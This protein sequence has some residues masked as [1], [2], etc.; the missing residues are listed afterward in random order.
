M[1]A[2]LHRVRPE[3]MLI[4]VGDH[5]L[6]VE[7]PEKVLFEADGITKSDLVAYY[8]AVSERF[9]SYARDHPMVLRRFPD[10]ISEPG[11][12][13]KQVPEWYPSWIR[14]VSVAKQEGVLDQLVCDDEATLVFLADQGAIE[15]HLLLSSTAA[16]DKPDR[17]IFDLD[18][19]PGATLGV[20]RA[21][22][23]DI[24]TLMGALGLKAY[25]MTSGSHGYHVVVPL[26][27]RDTFAAVHGFARGAAGLVASWDPAKR[28]TH[29][30]KSAREARVFI[31]Y[32]RNGYAQSAIAPY[33]V[34]AQPGAPVAMP[35]A[36]EELETA[37]PRSWRLK[38]VT[39][40]GP[41]HPDPWEDF[42]ANGVPLDAPMQLLDANAQEWRSR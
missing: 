41:R 37:E 6:L 8:R 16:L 18:P 10:G 28:T 24:Y 35:I 7:R 19:G 38:E 4:E 22:A 23:R 2:G 17:L 3:P 25:L 32:L 5:R 42:A 36:W 30:R 40:S 12:F 29:G 27:A 9:I 34:R 21:T 13:Q 39:R 26:A 20:L 15:L 33:S 1:Q 14:R 11:F 31:D